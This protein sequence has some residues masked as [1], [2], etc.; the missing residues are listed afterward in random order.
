MILCCSLSGIAY[1]ET[2]SNCCIINNCEWTTTSPN[3]LFSSSIVYVGP[4]IFALLPIHTLYPIIEF[5]PESLVI[6]IWIPQKHWWIASLSHIWILYIR[7]YF[8]MMLIHSQ[9]LLI[10]AKNDSIRQ[11]TKTRKHVSMSTIQQMS[12]ARNIWNNDEKFEMS[13]MR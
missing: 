4:V 12:R 11:K 3:A 13:V 7:P 6:T 10:H 2:C 1:I 8:S 5:L 9:L